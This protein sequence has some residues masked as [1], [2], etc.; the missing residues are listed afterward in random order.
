MSSH[1]I[2]QAVET[3][4]ALLKERLGVEVQLVDSA[5]WHKEHFGRC[6]DWSSWVWETVTGRD[7]DTR[8]HHFSGFI[9]CEEELG[10]ANAQLVELALRNG[11]S[12][13]FARKN[14]PLSTVKEVKVA[15]ETNWQRGWTAILEGEIQ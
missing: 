5:F 14:R 11:R 8:E 6:G 10:K 9:V 3:A 12:V 7:Y 1:A 15:D 13:L 4:D 2:N